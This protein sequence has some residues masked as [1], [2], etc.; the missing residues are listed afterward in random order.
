M[1]HLQAACSQV[2]APGDF[3]PGIGCVRLVKQSA[4]AV[5]TIGKKLGSVRP[6]ALHCDR[7]LD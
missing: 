6:S 2:D 1:T 3:T 7:L 4:V 5:G